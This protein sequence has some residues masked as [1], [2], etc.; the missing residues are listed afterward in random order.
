MTS[1]CSAVR[2]RR[3]VV[4]V[5]AAA[6]AFAVGEPAAVAYGASV[7]LKDQFESDTMI[8]LGPPVRLITEA[9]V[10]GFAVT[11]TVEEC[12][13]NE[14]R[15]IDFGAVD[16]DVDDGGNSSNLIAKDT[17]SHRALIVTSC[18]FGSKGGMGGLEIR[19]PMHDA[20]MLLY[21]DAHSTPHGSLPDTISIAQAWGATPLQITISDNI[22][23]WGMYFALS[24]PFLR[25]QM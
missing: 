3:A 15:V 9:T 22:L 18:Y 10:G 2:L 23:L 11:Y 17:P 6:L 1:R 20:A 24:G 19:G 5:F 4:A 25:D 14:P 21:D 16:N 12:G 7:P 8:S 13:V